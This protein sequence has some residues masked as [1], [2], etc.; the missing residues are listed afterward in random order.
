ME[1]LHLVKKFVSKTQTSQRRRGR[2]DHVLLTDLHTAPLGRR[3]VALR[4]QGWHCEGDGEGGTRRVRA[5]LR[6]QRLAAEVFIST[7]CVLYIWC[8]ELLH[9]LQAGAAAT[10]ARAATVKP[11]AATCRLLAHRQ[12]RPSDCQPPATRSS[13]L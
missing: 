4:G 13:D 7:A 9:R 6:G 11:T 12:A 8:V 10:A 3:R 5:A 1:L 2:T